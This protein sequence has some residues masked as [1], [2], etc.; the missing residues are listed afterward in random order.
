MDN[1]YTENRV[2]HFINVTADSLHVQRWRQVARALMDTCADDANP[3]DPYRL[4]A[5]QAIPSLIHQLE[6]LEHLYQ[7]VS[8]GAYAMFEAMYYA[9]LQGGYK[10]CPP[11]PMEAGVCDE[12]CTDRDIAACHL[13]WF[14]GV[15]ARAREAA[16]TKQ[17][18]KREQHDREEYERLKAKY[19]GGE[20]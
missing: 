13:E 5:N 16:E 9:A 10:R 19:E 18:A 3:D 20:A 7:E 1:Q 8:G 11:L 2:E 6:Y 15:A 4:L 14:V 17:A 12:C